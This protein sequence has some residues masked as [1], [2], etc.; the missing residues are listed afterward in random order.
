LV[1][2]QEDNYFNLNVSEKALALT[3]EI[4]DEAHRFA[5]TGMRRVRDKTRKESTLEQIP[6]IGPVRRKRLLVYFGGIAGIRGASIDD[7]IKVE[8]ISGEL[9]KEIYDT[10]HHH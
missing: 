3:I 2:L 9:A 4:R 1:N 8:G 5:I 6:G 10:L 7:L